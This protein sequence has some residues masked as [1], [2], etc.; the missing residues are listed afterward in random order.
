MAKKLTDRAKLIIITFFFFVFFFLVYVLTTSLSV[1]L[2]GRT[3]PIAGTQNN[4]VSERA[5][6]FLQLKLR[7]RAGV[8]LDTLTLVRLLWKAPAF[9]GTNSVHKTG[10]SPE[11][12]T[13]SNAT[14]YLRM[15]LLLPTR[16]GG[17]ASWYFA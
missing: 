4:T 1:Y 2:W 5:C 17:L 14:P 11:S 10:R 13:L 3:V 15:V 8:F 16:L 9:Y 7:C 12:N 6:L